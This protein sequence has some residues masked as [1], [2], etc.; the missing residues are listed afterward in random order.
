MHFGQIVANKKKGKKIEPEYYIFG[1]GYIKGAQR[2]KQYHYFFNGA[3]KMSRK[4]ILGEQCQIK[5]E[6]EESGNYTF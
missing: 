3:P 6:K 5:V 1:N 4:S 2:I